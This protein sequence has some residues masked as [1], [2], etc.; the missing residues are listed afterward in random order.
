MLKE[1]FN[2]ILS[3]KGKRKK[4]NLKTPHK[5][6]QEKNDLNFGCIAAQAALEKK[7]E[8]ILL[9]D[10]SRLTV[11]SDCFLIITARS[12]PQIEAIAKHIEETLTK[13][14][15]KPSSREGFASSNWAILDFG[16]LVVHIMNQ[17]ERDYYK[18]ERFWSNATVI[19][20]KIW[21]KAS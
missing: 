15:Y 21:R 2:V 11:I 6:K 7:G 1:R 3:L 5:P 8:D 12:T 4:R 19:D 20:K 18:L 10:V 16:N 9:L 14:N 13:L 17:K